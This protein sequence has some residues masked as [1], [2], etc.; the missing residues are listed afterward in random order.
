VARVDKADRET[1]FENEACWAKALPALGVTFPI[2]NIR[3]QVQTAR[4]GSRPPHRASGCTSA[5]RRAPPTSGSTRKAGPQCSA[6]STSSSSRAASAGSRSTCRRR[7]T[8]PR[9]RRHGSTRRSAAWSK[10]WYW[11]TQAG[12]PDRAKSDHA[13]YEDWVEQGWLTACS[14]ATIDKTFV[15]AEVAGSAPST[16]S[17]S[18]CS[19]PAQIADFEAACEEIGFPAWRFRGP[20]EPEGEGLKM[21]AHAQGTRV[22]FEDRQYCMPRS[23]ERLEDRILEKT[24][25]IDNS[26]VTYSCAA[27]AALIEDGM[28]NRAFD[29][30]RS[31]GRIDGIVTIAM[32]AGAADNVPLGKGSSTKSAAC[33]FSRRFDGLERPPGLGRAAAAR[34][35]ERR[36]SRRPGTLISTPQQLEEALRYG[37]VSSSG[38]AVTPTTAMRSARCSA[39][40]GSA[41]RPGD[42]ADLDIK[43]RVDERTRVDA[44]DHPVWQLFRR[45]P[46]KWM[47]PHQFKRMLQAQVCCAATATR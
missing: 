43:R 3:E 10:T 39:A 28:K 11:T 46:N 32:G 23:I 1:V 6:R 27:N 2:G 35:R 8:S 31:R 19:T 29:K 47:K 7:T 22:L 42:A 17:R 38:E 4:R 40:C 34:L 20:E 30:K 45:R 44:D 18:S 12:L 13:P 33:G 37:N 26:P 5:F 14:G 16:T 9:S 41:A 24:I 21:V 25:V 15:A 36:S